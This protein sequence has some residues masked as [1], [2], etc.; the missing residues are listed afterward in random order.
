[1]GKFG[2]AVLAAAGALLLAGCGGG[3]SDTPTAEENRELNNAAEMLDDNT[4]T[5]ASADGLTVQEAPIG[6]GDAGAA[7]TGELPV[8]GGNEASPNRPVVNAQ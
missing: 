1:M 4:I 8:D 7:A 2:G 6:N 5:D 3:D